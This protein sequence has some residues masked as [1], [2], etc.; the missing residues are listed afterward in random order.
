MLNR[1]DLNYFINKQI[2]NEHVD[3]QKHVLVADDNQANRLIAKTIL[4]RDNYKVTL[5]EDG[6]EAVEAAKKYNFDI[7]LM[8]IL[9]P[10]M[11]GIKALRRIKALAPNMTIP[12]IFAI[13]A[14]CSPAD[15]HRYRMAGFD[16]VLTKPLKHGDVELSLEQLSTGIIKTAIKPAVEHIQDYNHLEIL[17]QIII[18]Q[19]C[20]AANTSMLETIQSKFWADIERN[21]QTIRD[22]LP[23]ALN[24]MPE[25]LATMRKSVHSVKGLAASI[26]LL[27]ATHI[28]RHLQNAPPSHIRRLLKVLFETLHTS[29]APLNAALLQ[30]EPEPSPKYTPPNQNSSE[31]QQSGANAQIV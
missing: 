27:R 14:F 31:V 20:M 19:L 7:I 10:V 28:A 8:D 17:D 11:D 4:E 22:I 9:M 2:H 15:Q 24:A 3:S 6:L 13:T 25:A 26:G 1:D 23:D 21:S 16:A 5:V 12:P 18:N 29:K 30:T